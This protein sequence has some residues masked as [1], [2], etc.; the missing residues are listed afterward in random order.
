MDETV[1]RRDWQEPAH[2]VVVRHYD[3]LV[4]I[5]RV[6]REKFQSRIDEAF[7]RVSRQ[8]GWVVAM[9]L[10]VRIIAAKGKV[11]SVELASE[12][13]RGTVFEKEMA[14]LLAEIGKAGF[15]A[16]E[17]GE[18]IA[19][20]AGDPTPEPASV[21]YDFRLIWANALRVRLRTEW[22]EPAHV[23]PWLEPAH[24]HQPWLEPAHWVLDPHPD[25]WRERVSFAP[26]KERVLLSVL[27]EVYPEL[28]LMARVTELK[29][30]LRARRWPVGPGVPEPAHVDPLQRIDPRLMAELVRAVR[31]RVPSEVE[32]PVHLSDW[33][34]RLTPE[35][36]K[37]LDAVLKRYGM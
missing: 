16:L 24:L 33:A 29:A 32:E 35:L 20:N 11:R 36:L 17:G 13:L 15:P 27:D 22:L 28:Q 19:G 8:I 5:H 23:R 9:T 6:I 37:E 4:A 7:D 34:R 31:R 25:P 14:P 18:P 12:H 3:D 1:A 21:A 10:P 2:L 30:V 26:W